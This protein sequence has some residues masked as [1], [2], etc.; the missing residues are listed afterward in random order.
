MLGAALLNRRFAKPLMSLKMLFFIIGVSWHSIVRLF[1]GRLKEPLVVSERD[2]HFLRK[3]NLIIEILS[4]KRISSP[5][6]FETHLAK[7]ILCKR[8]EVK[9]FEAQNHDRILALKY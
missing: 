7:S 2:N 4:A 1:K 6:S 5:W 8:Q 9:L 3:F